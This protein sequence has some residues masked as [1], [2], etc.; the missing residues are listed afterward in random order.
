M[1][2][3]FSS[4]GGVAGTFYSINDVMS[5]TKEKRAVINYFANLGKIK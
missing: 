3:L 5:K 1:Q 4:I 2:K